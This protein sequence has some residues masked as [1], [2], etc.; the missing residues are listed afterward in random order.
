MDRVIYTA[1]NGAQQSFDQQAV[2][3]N[4]LANVTTPGFRA[5]LS[6]MQSVE[7]EGDG[8]HT[9]TL[10]LAGTPGADMTAGPV[11]A[12]GRALD[13]AYKGDAWIAVQAKDGS[14]A[15]TR[16]GDVQVDKNGMLNIGGLAVIGEAGPILVPLDAQVSVGSSGTISVIEAG[17]KPESIS[18]VARVKLV[19]AGRSQLERS[20]DGLFR[21]PADANGQVLPLP[22]DENA[23]LTSGSLEGSNVN[24]TSAMVDMINTQRRYDM[25]MKAIS[26]AEENEKAANSLL[27]MN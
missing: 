19:T 23:R 11:A 25:N 4:N 2:V 22:A 6:A 14:E 5:Q 16:R 18:E 24:A 17:Q 1:M 3:S 8:F 7:V 20:D 21:A 27:T 26:S 10:P 12:T 15:Y 9:R 13:F